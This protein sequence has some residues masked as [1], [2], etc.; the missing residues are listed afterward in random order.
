MDKNLKRGRQSSSDS[1]PS[2]TPVTKKAH[3]TME[4]ENEDSNKGTMA[5]H[6]PTE[7][8]NQA[9]WNALQ[10]MNKKLDTISADHTTVHND[11]YAAEGV[12]EKLTALDLD[13]DTAKSEIA[14]LQR[15]NS[16]LR[17][18]L[19]LL[20]SVVLKQNDQIET[21]TE[22]ITDQAFRSMRS[23]ILLHNLPELP[24]EN[25]QEYIKKTLNEKLGLGGDMKIEGA[26]RVGPRLHNAKNPR[27]MVARMHSRNDTHTIL[28]AARRKLQ[29]GDNQLRITP[30]F[31]TE[32]LSKRRT[33]G[34]VSSEIREKDPKVKTVLARDKLYINNT[35]YR[36]PLRDILNLTTKDRGELSKL[37]LVEGKV[38][39]GQGN[40]LVA[41]AAEVKSIDQAR[42]AYKKFLCKPERLAATSNAA[43]LR[44]FNPVGAV[45]TEY[46]EDDQ[47]GGCSAFILKHL[48]EKHTRF[49]NI[50]LFIS[51]RCYRSIPWKERTPLLL[52]AV[53]SAIR[54]AAARDWYTLPVNMDH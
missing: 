19:S 42:A 5:E 13:S 49:R 48:R 45:T 37:E 8:F 11:L 38:V 28:D 25:P 47:D 24:D 10:S 44:L 39:S 3:L 14:T 12:V 43:V 31:P 27:P 50:V 16:E 32:M 23:N 53:D 18:E 40:V 29:K 52:E 33:L 7:N 22:K 1:S 20:K 54:E 41:A 51:W 26:H 35:L 34:Q 2:K 21:L 17:Y 9:I 30:Q 36:N 4:T 15:E 6:P 46:K